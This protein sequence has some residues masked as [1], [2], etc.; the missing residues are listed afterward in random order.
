MNA[1][2]QHFERLNP[3]ERFLALATAAVVVVVLAMQL[4]GGESDS[5]SAWSVSADA[6]DAARAEYEELV[7]SVAAA[8]QIMKQFVL[9]VG[10]ADSAEELAAADAVVRYDLD[11]QN[12][13]AEWCKQIGM[14][15]PDFELER[16]EIKDVD[17][18]EM[19]AVTTFARDAD[20][21]RVSRLLKTFEL[22]GVIVQEVKIS[23][24]TDSPSLDATIRAARIVPKF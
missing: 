6:V 21:A 12:E 18:Y 15:T 19:V 11:F 17:E 7:A 13:V 23:N 14:P 16:E 8:P 10:T 4:L 2:R 1:L 24:R 9:L 5:D 22:R 20:L 3:R